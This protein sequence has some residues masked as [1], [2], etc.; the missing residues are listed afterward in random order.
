VENEGKLLC[1]RLTGEEGI[2]Q[3]IRA[4]FKLQ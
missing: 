2:K 1:L 3:F 4:E